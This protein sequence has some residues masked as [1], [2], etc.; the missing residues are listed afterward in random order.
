MPS[1]NINALV[2][3]Y[4]NED[5]ELDQQPP[6]PSIGLTPGLKG[7][8]SELAGQLAAVQNENEA[9]RGRYLELEKGWQD[10][11]DENAAVYTMNEELKDKLARSEAIVCE[12]DTTIQTLQAKVKQLEH[13]AKKQNGIARRCV[14]ELKEEQMVLGK[15][16]LE[17]NALRNETVN[18]DMEGRKLRTDWDDKVLRLAQTE[19]ACDLYKIELH[20]LG[21]AYT[22]LVEKLSFATSWANAPSKD[23]VQGP[24]GTEALK[25]F[26]DR[27]YKEQD[28]MSSKYRHLGPG[29]ERAPTRDNRMPTSP[30]GVPVPVGIEPGPA[31]LM[32]TGPTGLL[33][34]PLRAS[35][36]RATRVGYESPSYLRG[37]PSPAKVKYGM[38]PLSTRVVTALKEDAY[39]H[40]AF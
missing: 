27:I 12:K 37:S 22:D 21:V 35:P 16:N 38:S 24:R 10:V 4:T 33:M 29:Y 6:Q 11:L 13:E 20:R 34:S 17:C 19:E 36:E 31:G 2:N 39:S 9:V 23:L 15:K 32:M 26:L 18:L 30:G 14:D 8:L 3:K 40:S 28:M 25:D 1:R 7:K 5:K